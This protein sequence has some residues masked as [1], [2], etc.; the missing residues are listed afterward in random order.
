MQKPS[1]VIKNHLGEVQLIAHRAIAALAIITILIAILVSRLA[2]LQLE[3]NDLYTTLSKKNSLD[4]IPLE[5]I[6][7]LIYDRHG[8]LLADNI[9]VFSLDLI[10]Y[11][12]ENISQTLTE[13]N[14]IIPLSQA[15]ITQFKKQ[16]KDHHRFDEIPLKLRLSEQELALFY[17]NQYRFPGVVVKTR[18]IRYYPYAK[19]LSHL[20]GYVG[21]I[22]ANEL[23]DIDLVSYSASNY[24]GKLGIEKSYEEELHGKVGSRQVENDASGEPIRTLHETAPIAGENLYLTID[25]NLQLAAEQALEGHRG[26]IVAIQPA[27]GQI[28]AMVSA[29]SF[30]PNIFVAGINYQDY[31]TLQNSIDK[32]M[33][34]RAIRGSY[35]IA[36]TIKPY[37]AL[38][39]LNTGVVTPN[40]TIDD[41]GWYQLKNSE[42][43]FHDWQHHGHGIVNLSRAITSSCDTYFFDL[44]FKLG[45]QRIDDI[46]TQFGFGEATSIDINDE[47][48]GVVASPTW[49]LA[50]KGVSWYP[51]DTLN[52][53]IGQGYM[54][55][56]PLQLAAAIAT[57]ANRGARFLPYLVFGEQELGKPVLLQ[58]PTPLN[59]VVL[60]D[61]KYWDFVISAMQNVV[62][63]PQGTAHSFGDNLAYTAAAKTGTAQVYS[64]NYKTSET[65]HN[66]LNI[67]ERLRD[68]SLFVVFA[69]VDNP[70]IAVAVIVENGPHQAVSVARKVVDYYLTK[71]NKIIPQE[72]KPA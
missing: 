19:T 40:D 54:Q 48:P 43:I 2:Y 8:V 53:G 6:R 65:D 46:L 42:H 68:H 16:L 47:L 31:E 28:L 60:N 9:P 23:R 63:T 14:K 1:I 25:I 39:G 20:L 50:T 5:P 3:K 10:P 55:A 72:I 64:K 27:T 71:P 15:E 62:S 26:A 21:R 49:K 56:T 45:I 58:P 33:Y 67:P 32:P 36:S 51:G 69:P 22:N 24:I 66:Q 37:I 17:E 30:D 59:P 52:S 29:P 4:L 70:K 7:G 13:I 12:V 41:P 44:A 11:K 61:K 34:N 18:L 35:P 38:Q 57:M